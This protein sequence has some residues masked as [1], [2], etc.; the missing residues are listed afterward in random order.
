MTASPGTTGWKTELL[1]QFQ[2]YILDSS[3]VVPLNHLKDIV[4]NRFNREVGTRGVGFTPPVESFVC[5]DFDEAAGSI[6]KFRHKGFD[7][8]DFHFF[9]Y[10]PPLFMGVGKEAVSSQQS[11]RE[12]CGR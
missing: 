3:W 12:S 6:A 2:H 5:F 7:R 4:S 8:C 11:E 1:M 9:N 10:G